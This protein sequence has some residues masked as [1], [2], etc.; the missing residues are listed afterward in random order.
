MLEAIGGFP[1]HVIMGEDHI[2]VA[3]ALMK[4][5]T[6]VYDGPALPRLSTRTVIR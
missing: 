6:V 4:G 1:E 5:W 3:L 2:A